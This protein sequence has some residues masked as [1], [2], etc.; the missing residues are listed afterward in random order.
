MAT[1]ARVLLWATLLALGVG[2]A[3]EIKGYF[4]KDRDIALWWWMTRQTL[5]MQPGM[6]RHPAATAKAI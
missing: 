1:F 2:A 5:V 6:Q 3:F 4:G